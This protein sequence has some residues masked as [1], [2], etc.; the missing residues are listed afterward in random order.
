MSRLVTFGS[1][2]T[3]GQALP[4]TWDYKKNIPIPDQGPSKYAWPQLLANKLDVECINLSKPG[5]SNKEIWYTILNTKFKPD[6]K[7]I[8]LW[9]TRPRWCIIKKSSIENIAPFKIDNHK[10]S[11]YFLK[12]IYDECDHFID[13][14]LRIDYI[15]F[16]LMNKIKLLKHCI[17]HL[18]KFNSMHCLSCEMPFPK[19]F[20]SNIEKVNFVND[21][22]E[23]YPKAMDNQHTGEEGNKA[24]ADILYKDLC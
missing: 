24:F 13:F 14:C 21:I 7:V 18:A 12:Y 22:L 4:D 6:D 23:I 3:F 16:A 10:P 2:T 19:W 15:T 5:I 20:N 17:D 9:S 1:S 11:E 8:I